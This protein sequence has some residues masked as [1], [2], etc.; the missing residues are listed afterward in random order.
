MA[1]QA[2]EAPNKSVHLMFLSGGL[3]LFFLLVWTGDWVW[4]Y[5]GRHP[6]DFLIEG[7]A[8]LIAVVAGIVTYKNDRVFTLASEV[9]GELKKVT[10]PTKKE[11]QAATIV[12]IITVILAA[13]ILGLFDGV[14]SWLTDK[15]YG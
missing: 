4:G 11:T 1:T 7:M 12:V 13:I 5:F 2:A 10:W 3:I 6:N 9:A 14:W 8:A 15:I